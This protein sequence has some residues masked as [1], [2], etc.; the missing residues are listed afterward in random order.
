MT[1]Q[2]K[3]EE[4]ESLTDSNESKQKQDPS[5]QDQK[6]DEPKAVDP[7]E[8]EEELW[9]T[10]GKSN[11]E[12]I[13]YLKEVR[14]KYLRRDAEITLL[15]EP[16]STF[17]RRID[18]L[19]TPEKLSALNRLK[20]KD[21]RETGREQIDLINARLYILE[22]AEKQTTKK[23]ISETK[24]NRIK[25]KANSIP[26]VS[27]N[28]RHLENKMLK[29]LNGL[30]EKDSET[31]ISMKQLAGSRA[32][33]GAGGVI[34]RE[35]LG[36]W[37]RREDEATYYLLGGIIKPVVYE[38]ARLTLQKWNTRSSQPIAELVLPDEE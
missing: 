11:D 24:L 34:F 38:A 37:I 35:E 17:E 25:I 21:E 1:K 3:E 16:V 30:R 15:L 13:S 4:K 23:N 18:S 36:D 32:E 10:A 31:F 27:R 7:I 22:H 12:K 26:Y 8:A 2:K 6:Q 5:V 19:G 14:E 29:T 20:L 28:E 9:I 33:D